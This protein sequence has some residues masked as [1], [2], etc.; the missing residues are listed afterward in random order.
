MADEPVSA[1]REPLARRARRRADRNRTAVASVAVALIAG[2]VGLSV[3][4]AV[5]T[6]AK[7]EV[8]RALDG[9]RDAKQ[10]LADSNDE[11]ARPQQATC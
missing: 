7:A 3:V 9:E 10:A 2:V 8:T 5:Q 4:L 11:L 1:W 6:Q